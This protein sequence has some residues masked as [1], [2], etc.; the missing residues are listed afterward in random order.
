MG[1]TLVAALQ[2]DVGILAPRPVAVVMPNDARL[3]EYR[4]MFAGRVGLFSINPNE[5]L[6]NR[7]RIRRLLR[8]P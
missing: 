7:A 5:R 6:G 8:D 3:G 4:S 1:A 2:D